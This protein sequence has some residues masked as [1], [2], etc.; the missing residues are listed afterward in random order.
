MSI[1][2]RLL[3]FW[4]GGGGWGGGVAWLTIT[5]HTYIDF[6]QLKFFCFVFFERKI[7]KA[8]ILSVI[9]YSQGKTLLKI[10]EGGNPRGAFPPLNASLYDM[11]NS[12]SES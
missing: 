12:T 8:V 4:G 11:I 2:F 9:V 6:K 1:C 7:I 5:E 3:F 10:E